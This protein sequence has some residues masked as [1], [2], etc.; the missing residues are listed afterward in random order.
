MS[1]LRRGEVVGKPVGRVRRKRRKRRHARDSRDF[2]VGERG[3]LLRQPVARDRGRRPRSRLLPEGER[4]AFLDAGT[5]EPII[6]LP[7]A[8]SLALSTRALAA[9]Q[10][11]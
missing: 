6:G 5:G 8:E 3:K 9:L 4:E 7:W 1:E 2:L 10:G 11:A